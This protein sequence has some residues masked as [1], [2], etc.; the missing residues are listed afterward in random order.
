MKKKI[1]AALSALTLGATMMG[2]MAMTASKVSPLSRHEM[3][4]LS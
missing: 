1:L 2:G 4:N 3:K